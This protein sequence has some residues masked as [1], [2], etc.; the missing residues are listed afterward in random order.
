MT[1]AEIVA[2]VS[3]FPG[4]AVTVASEETGAPELAWGSTFFFYDP[5]DEEAA[6]RFPFATIVVDDVPDFDEASHLDRP[7]IFRVN[8]WVERETAA[9]VA[10]DADPDALDVPIR[11]PVYGAQGWVSILNPETSS[12]ILSGLLTEAHGRAVERHR[13]RK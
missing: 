6:R 10:T 7:D 4:A 11:H 1:E 12:P 8:V 5:D 13:R 2:S 9:R 3:Q